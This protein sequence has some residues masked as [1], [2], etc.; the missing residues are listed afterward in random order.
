M[1]HSP[2]MH[3]ISLNSKKYISTKNGCHKIYLSTA[4]YHLAFYRPF[5]AQIWTLGSL[6]NSP[7]TVLLLRKESTLYHSQSTLAYVSHL[8]LMFCSYHFF[9]PSAKTQL[10]SLCYT[11]YA[12]FLFKMNNT[13]LH[14]TAC[15]YRHIYIYSFSRRFY[16]KRLTIEEYNKRYII[17]RQT[18]TWSACHTTF[19]ALFRAKTS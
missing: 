18:F 5:Q 12:L 4:W 19:Q 1:N 11:N 6:N 2:C 13:A 16:P 9:I 7:A 8:W 3:V 10:F 15:H 14:T 17:K